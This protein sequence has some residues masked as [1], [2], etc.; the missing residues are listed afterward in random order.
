MPTKTSKATHFFNETAIEIEDLDPMVIPVRHINPVGG[1]RHAPGSVKLAIASPI[2]PEL[3]DEVALQI[4]DLH[5]VITMIHH[6]KSVIGA[7]RHFQN[8]VELAVSRTRGAEPFDE[9]IVCIELGDFIVL[10]ATD[11]DVP[12]RIHRDAMSILKIGSAV[13]AKIQAPCPGRGKY[14]DPVIIVITGKHL[15]V[16]HRQAHGIELSVA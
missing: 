4:K 7:D 13:G 1:D 5:P 10:V 6:V 9:V 8:P 12:R 2:H 15:A 14:R 16:P 3:A 11:V